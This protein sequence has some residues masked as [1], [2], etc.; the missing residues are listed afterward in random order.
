MQGTIL[1]VNTS[2][3][4]LPKY[5]VSEGLAGFLGIEGDEH[6][7]TRV[8]GGPDKA[9]LLVSSED[10]DELKARGYPLFYGALGENLTTGG[11]D[12]RKVRL[13]DKYRAGGALLEISVPRMPCFNL[14]VYGEAI[15]Q[16]IWDKRV[17][18][19]DHTTPRWGRA[20]FYARVLEPGPIG[21][22]DIIALVATLA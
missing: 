7:N 4:G 17:K 3:G 2:K 14:D 10:I 1:Q 18:E 22:G 20:G 5:P 16:E 13:G 11:L 9:I 21:T 15:K 6:R 12:F 8:H 19:R